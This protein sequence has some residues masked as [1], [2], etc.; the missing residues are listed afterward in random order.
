MLEMIDLL[1]ASSS[2]SGSA[3]IPERLAAHVYV[4]V[5][6][7]VVAGVIAL[8]AG[9][10][11]GHRNRGAALASAVANAGRAI[12]TLALLG[13]ATV[14]V[15]IGFWPTLI[16]MVAPAIPPMFTNTF[17]GTRG[18]D[19]SVRSAAVG[20]GFEDFELLRQ[21]EIPLAMPL[22]LTGVR[23]AALQ[24]VAT[25][26]LG[27]LVGFVALGSFIEEGRLQPDKGKLLGGSLL[28][29][30]LALAADGLVGALAHRS[31]RWQRLGRSR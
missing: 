15:G 7:M 19:P 21:V 24:V 5:L 27:A 3:G 30:V 2:W 25:A 16:A 18:V 22:I 12:P 6:S 20:M 31:S 1:T 11:L 28:V 23:I 9:L 4:S 17:T 13:L 26:T 29:I 10:W 14:A 8:P